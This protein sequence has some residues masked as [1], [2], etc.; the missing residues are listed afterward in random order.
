MAQSPA[1]RPGP[2][3]AGGFDFTFDPSHAA[4]HVSMAQFLARHS[5]FD[6]VAVGALVF[7]TA[8][9][10][11]RGDGPDRALLVQRAAHCSSWASRLEVPGGGCDAADKTIVHALA[12]ELREE[13]G[14]LLKKVVAQVG[15]E[16]TFLSK[17]GKRICKF[18]FEVEVELSEGRSMPEVTI[19]PKEHQR[20]VWATEAECR[21]HRAV[22]D[23]VES[24]FE[25]TTPAEENAILEGFSLR[26]VGPLRS[27][28]I[29][30]ST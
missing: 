15:G 29:P 24:T 16:S 21:A 6:A 28:E 4:F 5:E 12:R 25:F 26:N 7:A 20:F 18:V 30:P 13:T 8:R 3:P 9:E 14:L 11:V 23:G 22:M 27:A 10:P 1:A 2:P 19:D 17:R